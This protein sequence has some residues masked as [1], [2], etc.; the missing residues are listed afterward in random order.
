MSK[1]Q[2]F[3]T[4]TLCPVC[5]TRCRTLESDQVTPLYREVHYQ[6]R[7]DDCTFMFVASIT[8][9]RTIVPPKVENPNVVIPRLSRGH[10]GTS[11]AT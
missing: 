10:H 2:N 8:P 3:S 1:R 6:C 4:S 5:G 11:H 9:V 7:N